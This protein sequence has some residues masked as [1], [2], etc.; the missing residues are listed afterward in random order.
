MKRLLK[1][2]IYTIAALLVIFFAGGYA[3]PDKA[4]VARQAVINAPPEKVFAIVGDLKR[5]GEWS[6]W[7]G[8]DPNMKVT[9][10][11]PA[12]KDQK[13][14]WTSDDPN[15][16]NGSQTTIDFEPNK[17]VVSSLD[18][19]PMGQ[20]VASMVLSE[21]AGKG[22]LVEW[23]FSTSLNNPMERWMGLMF[24]RWIG[25]DYEKGLANLKALAE[26]P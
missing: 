6:P 7:F 13:M 2:I 18:F 25:A 3:L 11:G 23:D 16:G 19:G 5:S 17:R 4:H 26:K 20:A 22:T 21:A 8:L 12:G 24:D 10:E 15:V 14:S 9:V 1:A